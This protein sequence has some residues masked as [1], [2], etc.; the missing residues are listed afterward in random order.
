MSQNTYLEFN[1]PIQIIWRKGTADDPFVDRLDITKVVNQRIALLEIPDELYRVRIANMQEINYEKFIKSNLA[2][3]EYY[4]DYSNGFVY[5]NISKEAL[6]ISI[7]YKGRGLILYPTSRIV[8]SDG[9]NPAE[10]LHD[11]I[12]KTKIQIIHLIDE[13]EDF[14]EVMAR[15]VIATN[16]TNEASD[17]AVIA[18]Q[19]ANTATELVQDAY[20][21]TVLT[22]QPFV[23][24]E[25]DVRTTYPYPLVGWTVQVFDTGVRYRFNGQD[26]I[27]IDAFGGNIPLASKVIDGLLSKELFTKLDAITNNVDTRAIV[28]VIPEE[29]LSG[30]QN[31][32]VAFPFDGE[33]ED[34][35]AFVS[36]G[37]SSPTSIRVEKSN[38]M[39][40][41]RAI[42]SVP[43]QINTNEYFDNMSHVIS[44]KSVLA[45]DIFRLYVPFSGDVSNLTL[46]IK[47][48]LI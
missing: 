18:A 36:I 28:F 30:I 2:T 34:I 37:G 1:N 44:D 38:N 29:V 48:K 47:I 35:K 22:Y 46:S 15:M 40:D 24:T 21:T 17:R 27:P 10:T 32:H 3:D 43:V 7:V 16:I 6:T 13:T 5:F 42:T 41:W 26:W 8:H 33:I 45:G 31:P 4:V 20:K 9:T 12:E 39:V 19:K 23:M 14:E 11:L 25:E